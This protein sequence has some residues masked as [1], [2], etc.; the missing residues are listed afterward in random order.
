[1]NII[2]KARVYGAG[3]GM[4]MC[5]C[6]R[7]HVWKCV[8]AHVGLFV[9]ICAHV[10]MFRNVRC[11]RGHVRKYMVAHVRMFGNDR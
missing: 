4:E 5:G 11:A 7:G 2:M 8:A 3:E 9:N 1:M 6:A 10:C